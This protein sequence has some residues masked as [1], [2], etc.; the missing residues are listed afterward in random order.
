MFCNDLGGFSIDPPYF[1][2]NS[3]EQENPILYILMF[4]EPSRTQIDLGFF[5]HEYFI[6]GTF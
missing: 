1:G 5:W 4:Q 6:M 3:T 2:Y